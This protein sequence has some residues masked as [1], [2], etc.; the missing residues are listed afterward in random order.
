MAKVI[1]SN[2]DHFTQTGGEGTDHEGTAALER[3]WKT[4][5]PFS[6]VLICN[7]IL[8]FEFFC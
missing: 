2:P 1:S 8:E 7:Q 5:I 4:R 6:V 3:T